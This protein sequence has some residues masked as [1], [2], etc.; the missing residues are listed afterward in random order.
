MHPTRIL[1]SPNHK[2]IVEFSLSPSIA[3]ISIDAVTGAHA[4]IARDAYRD[5]G[6][7]SGHPTQL[8]FGDCFAYALAKSRGEPLLFKGND[9][10]HTNIIYI[11]PP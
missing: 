8:N 2:R 5:F 11:L 3:Q 1:K 10:N 7:G 9:F 6:K 4:Q